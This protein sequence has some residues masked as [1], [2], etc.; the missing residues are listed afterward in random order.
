M[1]TIFDPNKQNNEQQQGDNLSQPVNIS[2]SAAAAPDAGPSASPASTGGTNPKPTSSGRFQNLNAYLKA[3][4]GFNREGG[5]LAGKVNQNLTSRA[6]TLQKDFAQAQQDYQTTLNNARQRYD[7]QFVDQSLANPEQADVNKFAQYRDATYKGPTELDPN[8]TLRSQA[9]NFSN[10]ANNTNTEGGRLQLLNQLYNKPTY[11]RGQKALDNLFLQA[12][13]DQLNS[14]KSNRIVAN[15]VNNNL[16]QAQSE[17][18]AKAIEATQEANATREATR[19]AL[20]GAITGFDANMQNA[21]QQAA[22][23]RDQKFG[24]KQTDLYNTRLGSDEAIKWGLLKQLGDNQSVPLFNLDLQNYLQKSNLDPTKQTVASEADYNRINALRN[25]AGANLNE[26]TSKLF[27]MFNDPSLAGSF[28]KQDPYSFNREQFLYDQGQAQANYQLQADPYNTAIA[29]A[30]AALYTG[31]ANTGY[32]QGLIP[33]LAQ[34]ASPIRQ[35]MMDEYNNQ[36][37][38]YQAMGMDA[39]NVT[40]PNVA[41]LS[42]MELIRQYGGASLQP[43]IQGIEGNQSKLTTYQSLL[44]TLNN[45][46]G[47][48]RRATI[49]DADQYTP[50]TIDPANIGATPDILTALENIYN[51]PSYKPPTDAER[52]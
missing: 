6:S 21:V 28:A 10:L 42:D 29:Q 13:P 25:L 38:A 3:N 36:L 51:Q 45:A 14:L 49:T 5:G 47:I 22:A 46:S 24:Q 34:N 50:V 43:L 11:S 32:L 23:A 16:G 15:Q 2:G 41:N 26:N 48:N 7:Q 37:A 18:A 8:R 9:E 17:A 4:Q 1:A 52:G 27:D 44:D 30:N 35:Q 40:V 33:A 19:N 31:D 39:S 20:G 12:N